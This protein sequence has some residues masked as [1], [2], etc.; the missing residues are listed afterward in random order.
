MQKWIDWKIRGLCKTSPPESVQKSEC[1]HDDYRLDGQGSF[2][3][4]ALVIIHLIVDITST[5][6]K[7]FSILPELKLSQFY[8]N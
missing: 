4:A 7:T 6:S 8:L 3:S 5:L 1:K 2:L